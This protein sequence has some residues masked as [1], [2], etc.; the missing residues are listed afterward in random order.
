MAKKQTAPHSSSPH[1]AY[2]APG[3][4]VL[5]CWNLD[6]KQAIPINPLAMVK[7]TGKTDELVRVSVK[8]WIE[9][10][11]LFGAY[12]HLVPEVSKE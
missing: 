8:F 7:G 11:L 5:S 10:S 2:K 6:I 1:S 9:V 12:S 3:I 4:K